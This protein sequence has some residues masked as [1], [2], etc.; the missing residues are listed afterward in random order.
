MKKI[1]FLFVIGLGMFQIANSQTIELIGKGVLNENIATITFTDHSSV[2]YVVVEAAAVF[3]ND[4]TPKQ[5]NFTDSNDNYKVDFNLAEQDF[6]PGITNGNDQKW[7]YYTA[8][9]YD[10]DAGGIT[11]DKMGQGENIL[12]F[13]AYVYRNE[14]NSD[15]YSEV[16]YDHA[17]FFHN[18]AADP[19]TYNFTL[20]WSSEP[21]DIEVVVPISELTEDGRYVNLR[22]TAGSL[23]LPLE[24]DSNNKGEL[25]NL[26]TIVLNNV[27]GDITDVSLYIYSPKLVPDGKVGDSFVTGAILL[28]TTFNSGCT[29][30]QGYWKTH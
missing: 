4:L 13:T 16:E 24:F 30:T 22:L 3:R 5:V 2:D 21:R 19:L 28:T 10:V 12:S 25:L 29:H 17:F 18:G 9:F 6:A 20:P 1:V 27:P 7:G 8:I 26:Q 15:I 23:T 14:S 11:L